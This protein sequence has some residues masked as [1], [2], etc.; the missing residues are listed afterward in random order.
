MHA[1]PIAFGL[2]GSATL[3][4][5]AIGMTWFFLEHAHHKVDAWRGFGWL[6]WWIVIVLCFFSA[7]LVLSEVVRK[8]RGTIL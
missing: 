7:G 4:A 3:A 8:F 5:V 2:V 1:G 6:V